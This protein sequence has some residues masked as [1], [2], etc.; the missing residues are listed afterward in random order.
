M[1]YL[2]IFSKLLTL[3]TSSGSLSWL[4]GAEQVNFRWNV[5]WL[6]ETLVP[7]PWPPGPASPRSWL[8]DLL[9][10]IKQLFASQE[11]RNGQDSST[12]TSRPIRKLHLSFEPIRKLH[13][14]FGPIGNQAW[15]IVARNYSA[16]LNQDIVSSIDHCLPMPR[17]LLKFI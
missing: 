2:R 12:L 15:Q 11:H 14:S 8:V 1:Y 7:G 13:L 16:H 4:P 9:L 3:A 6:L 10:R 5:F 17:R